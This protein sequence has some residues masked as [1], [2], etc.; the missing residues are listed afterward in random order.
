MGDG[1]KVERR[2][3]ESVWISLDGHQDLH[4]KHTGV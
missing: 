2:V 3:A 1:Q 4:L